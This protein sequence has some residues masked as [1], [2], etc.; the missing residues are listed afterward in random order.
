MRGNLRW[1]LL[2]AAASAP[3]CIVDHLMGAAARTSCVVLIPPDTLASVSVATGVLRELGVTGLGSIRGSFGMA[4]DGRVLVLSAFRGGDGMLW[5]SRDLQT[6]LAAV[7]G[8]AG[9]A[10]SVAYTGTDWVAARPA[11][12]QCGLARYATLQALADGVPSSVVPG[13]D[14]AR[15]TVAQQFLY[16]ATSLAPEELEVR[17]L[18]TGALTRRVS[19]DSV[20]FAGVGGLSVSDGVLYILSRGRTGGVLRS[21]ELD[22]GRQAELALIS[23][24]WPSGLLCTSE[25]ID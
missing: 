2:L 9:V 8:D 17:G 1:L 15:F 7:L 13:P 10:E 20:L 23:G 3:S 12:L 16:G 24:A 18:D 5:I 6:G 14:Y 19:L 4:S 11:C 22:T 25:P 21:V